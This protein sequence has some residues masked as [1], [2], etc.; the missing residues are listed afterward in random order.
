MHCEF[1]SKYLNVHHKVAVHQDERVLNINS[2]C[3]VILKHKYS[4]P[5]YRSINSFPYTLFLEYSSLNLRINR[6]QPLPLPS[7]L[8]FV[9][10]TLS[11]GLER[12]D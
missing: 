4:I 1:I 3:A 9:V 2:L 10:P 5:N 12:L 11:S 6:S 8:P 7:N